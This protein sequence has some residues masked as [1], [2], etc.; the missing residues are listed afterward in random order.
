[1]LMSWSG[2]ARTHLRV[3]ILRRV[4]ALYFLQTKKNISSKKWQLTLRQISDNSK[5]IWLALWVWRIHRVKKSLKGN[6]S[7][8]IYIG[9]VGMPKHQNEKNSSRESQV[10]HLTQA[11]QTAW[12]W[13]LGR[14]MLGGNFWLPRWFFFILVF[15]HSYK[16]YIDVFT[17]I[18]L[19][20]FFLPYVSFKPTVYK[21]KLRIIG[22]QLFFIRNT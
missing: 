21:E 7:E 13:Q 10:C 5:F 9:L 16:A 3:N 11:G 8:N 1:M 18:S 17:W 20:T 6:S 12:F 2:P 22:V 4:Q 15:W 19:Q 14:P